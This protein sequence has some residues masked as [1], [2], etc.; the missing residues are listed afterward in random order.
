M[1]GKRRESQRKATEVVGVPEIKSSEQCFNPETD[2]TEEDWDGMLEALKSVRRIRPG[3]FA[4]H[5]KH[6]AVLFPER[7]QELGLDDAWIGCETKL[8]NA[9]SDGKWWEFAELAANLAILFPKRRQELGLDDDAWDGMKQELENKYDGDV[10]FALDM[11]ILFPER[12]QE[13]RLDDDGWNEMKQELESSNKDNS[14]MFSYYST[15]V[16][17]SILHPERKQ[18]LGL[19][20][21]VW[22]RMV[23][24][25]ERS[26]TEENWFRVAEY[27]MYM[28]ILGADRVDIMS[29]GQLAITPK[30]QGI[31]GD[32]PLPERPAV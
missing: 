13:L 12:K 8:Y 4:R 5:A 1:K 23:N 20:S 2:L 25:F 24:F 19:D 7:K 30:A 3:L 15:A 22:T 18:E 26:R 9:R 10:Q 28:Y 17:A 14:W 32:Q 6:M 16:A 11:A 31:A 27:A 21:A 29:D